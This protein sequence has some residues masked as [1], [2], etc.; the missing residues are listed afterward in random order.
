VARNTVLKKASI[1][2]NIKRSELL[3][4]T[5]EKQ[6]NYVEKY[7][8]LPKFKGLL[9]S[10]TALYLA[11]NYPN[12]CKY[13]SDKNY[14]VYDSTNDAYDDNPMFK[15]EKEEYYYD[16]KGNKKFY[17]DKVGES[18]VWEFE[19][20]INE[21][22]EDGKKNKAPFY[23]CLITGK[24][25]VD[26]KEI[27]TYYIY[28]IGSIEKNI[29]KK[30]K[31]IYK[32]KYQYLY[33]DNKYKIHDLGIFDFTSTKEMNPGNIEGNKNVELLDARQFKGYDKDGVKLKFKTWNSD[34]ERWYINPDCFASLLGAMAKENIDYIGFNGFSDDLAR[35]VGGSKSHRNGEKGDLR[36]I[37][38]NRD[39]EATLLEDSDFDFK[40][41]NKFNDSLYLFGWGR[42]EK[43]YSEYFKLDKNDETLLNHTK[44]MKKLGK[45][46]YRHYHHLHLC[47]FD[48]SLI[49][50]NS[51]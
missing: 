30:V 26:D 37:S 21:F 36:Y 33:I 48:H 12:S 13:A 15:R 19:E 28:E 43:M 1:D 34:S 3:N 46:G 31:D 24:P 32:T 39:G 8:N 27:I 35:S 17:K 6:L 5:T 23:K 20:A 29:P 40:T 49:L 22:Y 50:I 45:D 10:K 18:K 9:I 7:F 41:Q 47:G 25:S 14:V 44:H 11:V 2:I 42:K 51:N 4:M 38:T 16:K